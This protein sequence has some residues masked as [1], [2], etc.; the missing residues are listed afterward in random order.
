MRVNSW[1]IYVEYS[2]HLHVCVYAV[3]YYVNLTTYSD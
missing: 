3:N 1:D 2:V